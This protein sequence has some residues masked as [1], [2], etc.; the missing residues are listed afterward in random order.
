MFKNNIKKLYTNNITSVIITL[1]IRGGV[2]LP[3][4]KKIKKEYI[5]KASFKI[6]KEQEIEKVTARDIAKKLNSSVQPMF[7][8]FK[9]I[10][11]LKKE[12]LNYSLDYYHKYI[13]INSKKASITKK[14]A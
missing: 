12:L 1:D 4:S 13:S 6:L 8:Q 7:Y 14:L 9:N 3:S 2:K 5:I 11:D 10:E